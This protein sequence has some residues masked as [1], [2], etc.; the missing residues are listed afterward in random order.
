[1]SGGQNWYFYQLWGC[2][3]A[4]RWP[5]YTSFDPGLKIFLSYIFLYTI[6]V[7]PISAPTFPTMDSDR[8]QQ[9][10]TFSDISDRSEQGRKQKKMFFYDF[11]NSDHF[12]PYS[13]VYYSQTKHDYWLILS[14]LLLINIIYFSRKSFCFET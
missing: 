11:Q 9:I 4:S 7:P 6:E 10:P 14:V 5:T 2:Y 3:K 8:F 1:M 13:F 12:L